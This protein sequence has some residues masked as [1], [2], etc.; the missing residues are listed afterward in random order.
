MSTLKPK[1][2]SGEVD[3]FDQRYT[4]FSRPRDSERSDSAMLA[5]GKQHY[6]VRNFKKDDGYTLRDWAFAMGSWYL[7]RWW[8]FGNLVG[9]DGLYEWFPDQ[10]KIEDRDRIP[11]GEKWNVCDPEEMTRIVKKAALYLGASL[12]GICKVDRR[13]I[14][15]HRFHPQTLEHTPIEEIPEDFEYAIVMAHEMNYTLMRTAPTYGEN[16]ATGRGYSMMAYVASSVAHFVRDLGYKAIPSG[17]DTALSIPMAVD[18]GLGELGRHGLLI[19]QKF[20]PRVRISKVLTNLPLVPDEAIEFGVREMC[21]FCS[22]CAKACPGQAISF[23]EPSLQGS[24]VSNNHGLYKWYIHPEKCFQFWVRNRGDCAICIRE[25]VFNKPD[26]RFH[27]FV[28]WHVKNLPQFDGFYLWMD[29]V[30]G[31]GKKIKMED[32]WK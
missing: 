3:R 22:R 29:E 12:V 24:T 16:A 8:G 4:M 30:C 11:Q 1:I 13:W 31:Y 14:Y 19:T 2:G 10:S 7:E 23:G 21:D 25:C 9:N 26:N 6:G 17:N 15:S 28:K 5:L 27:R 20:G 32:I 18:A